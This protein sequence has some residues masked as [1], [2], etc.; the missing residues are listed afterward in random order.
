[1]NEIPDLLRY[2]VPAEYK[3]LTDVVLSRND[4]RAVETFRA[5]I[6]FTADI[7]LDNR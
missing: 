1:M 3:A 5:H 4:Y 7:L 6:Q 2:P